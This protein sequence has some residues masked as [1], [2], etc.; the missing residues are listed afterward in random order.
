MGPLTLRFE[1][2]KKD[3][4]GDVDR[5]RLMAVALIV[6]IAVIC[7]LVAGIWQMASTGSVNQAVATGGCVFVAVV[8]VEF[9]IVNYLQSR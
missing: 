8:G 2:P 4:G 9:L 6:A 1:L 3:L 7:A 5:M